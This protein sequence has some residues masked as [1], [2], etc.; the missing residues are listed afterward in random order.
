MNDIENIPRVF[1][2]YAWSSDA[3][4][5]WV[6]DLGERLMSDGIDVVLDQWSLE[7]G[8]DVNVFMEKMVSDSSIKRVVIISD[9]VYSSKANDRKGGVGTETQIISNEVYD[10]VDQNKFIPVL[11]ERD[12]KGNP[13]LPIYLKSRKY[14]DFSNADQ[15]AEAY[16]QLVRNI[17][18]RPKRQ[19]PALGP[20]PAHIFDDSPVS[21]SS[22]QKA[23]RFRETVSSGKGEPNL[24]FNDFLDEF[25]RNLEDLRIEYSQE[26]KET[27]CELIKQNIDSSRLIRDVFVDVVRVAVHSSSANSFFPILITFFEKLL[28]FTKRPEG[29]GTTFEVSQDNYKFIVYE[30]FLYTVASLIQAR[31]FSSVK[32]LITHQY[33]S[34]RTFGGEDMQSFC[35]TSFNQ[36]AKSL[37]D[38]CSLQG[39][40]RRLS[41]MAD[42]LHER[43]TRTDIRFSDLIQAD[44]VL[45]LAVNGHGWNPRSMIYWGRIGK[46][47]LFIR[48]QTIEG[49][50]PLAEMLS[51]KSPKELVERMESESVTRIMRS[52]AFFH[53]DVDRG[54]LNYSELKRMW[55]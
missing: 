54:L 17:F 37:E 39:N 9:S 51:I 3:H 5:A 48:A 23:K 28:P 25:I 20:P 33:V 44:A 43:A 40:S 35:F 29:F 13:C 45:C 34:P 26:L 8:H 22:A 41:V 2:S 11:R 12:E 47:E 30:L 32:L 31:K 49:F 53:A 52:K 1:I 15:E 24:A 55:G 10:S 16:D 46:L 38:L 18:E 7:D 42:L 21:V 36:Y 50:Q 27:W 14:I 4:T 6:A 19:K